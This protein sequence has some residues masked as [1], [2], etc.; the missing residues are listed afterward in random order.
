MLSEKAQFKWQVLSR[1][2]AQ[3][4]PPSVSHMS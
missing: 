2:K 3:F 1:W 4:T